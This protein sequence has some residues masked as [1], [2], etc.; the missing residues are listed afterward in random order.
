MVSDDLESLRRLI[1]ENGAEWAD[2][3]DLHQLS[4]QEFEG[5]WDI[6]VDAIRDN[7]V[8]MISFGK[9]CMQHTIEKYPLAIT[10][11]SVVLCALAAALDEAAKE[12]KGLS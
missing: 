11:T 6:A 9:S 10:D 7:T 1:A 4:D 3:H 5:F 8:E 12:L 2:A